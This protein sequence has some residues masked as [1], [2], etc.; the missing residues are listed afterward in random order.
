MGTF[1]AISFLGFSGVFTI[2]P[3]TEEIAPIFHF[4]LF[5]IFSLFLQ[6]WRSPTWDSAFNVEIL[7]I[8]H[9]MLMSCKISS[10][11]C[12][13]DLLSFLLNAI[14]RFPPGRG[15]HLCVWLSF[16]RRGFHLMRR[17]PFL[18]RDATHFMGWQTCK[19]P[20]SL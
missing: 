12:H 2:F 18:K 5:P 11:S 17:S 1:R 9:L 14:S 15:S 3:D 8:L 20:I 4:C 19:Y 10:E 6:T 13:H 16:A 7:S